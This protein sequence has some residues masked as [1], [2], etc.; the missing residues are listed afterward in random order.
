MERETGGSQ[1]NT[2]GSGIIA[3]KNNA[4]QTF[5]TTDGKKLVGRGDVEKNP[6]SPK[7]TH[8]IN[9]FTDSNDLKNPVKIVGTTV[10]GVGIAGISNGKIVL[11]K[12]EVKPKTKEQLEADAKDLEAKLKETK[13]A[14]AKA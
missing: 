14:I 13:A 1:R 9:T 2:S 3:W 10:D 6:N 7:Y 11:S 12:L 5:Y 8:I 4:P